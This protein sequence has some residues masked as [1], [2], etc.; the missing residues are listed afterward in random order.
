LKPGPIDIG[1]GMGEAKTAGGT[2]ARPGM[3]EA[4][5]AGGTDA[6]SGMGEAKT[7]GG[8]GARPGMSEGMESFRAYS[9][10]VKYKTNH[11]RYSGVKLIIAK[12]K[13]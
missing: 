8:T 5:T 11:N 9:Y 12:G 13:Q 3:G 6:R 4:E 2:D 7:A 1:P 10:E